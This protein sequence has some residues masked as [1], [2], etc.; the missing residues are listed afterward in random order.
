MYKLPAW[1]TR[2]KQYAKKNYIIFC[3]YDIM[4]PTKKIETEVSLWW[5][6]MKCFPST[7]RARN[8]KTQQSYGRFD[9]SR[10]DTS[11]F[12]TSRF[13][14]NRSRFDTHVKSFR[15]TFKV[16]SLQTEVNSIQPLFS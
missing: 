9:T 1:T 15:Y 6:R 2:T 13:D 5:I 4:V 7:L 12:D 8:F 10:F 3:R 16:D 14:T 11:R